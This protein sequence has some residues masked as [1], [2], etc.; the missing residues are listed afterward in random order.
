VHRFNV[1]FIS[2]EEKKK[3]EEFRLFTSFQGGMRTGKKKSADDKPVEF[4]LLFRFLFQ[5]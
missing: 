2:A 5:R 1:T 4:V 3:R